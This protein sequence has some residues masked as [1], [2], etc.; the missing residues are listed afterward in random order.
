MTDTCGCA[1]H[2][3]DDEA[4]HREIHRTL[5]ILNQMEDPN[6]FI[7]EYRDSEQPRPSLD[8]QQVK[9]TGLERQEVI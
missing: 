2:I 3:R 7:S 4:K 6:P 1:Q 9:S 8:V 5:G